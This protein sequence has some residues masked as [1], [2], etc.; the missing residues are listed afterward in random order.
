MPFTANANPPKK[1][2]PQTTLRLDKS[3][4]LMYSSKVIL[5]QQTIQGV[6]QNV[7]RF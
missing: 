3:G 1:E 2:R 7:I 4:L 5:L 6:Y